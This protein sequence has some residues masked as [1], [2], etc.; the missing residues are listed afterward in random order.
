MRQRRKPDNP[1][2]NDDILNVVRAAICEDRYQFGDHALDRMHE[3]KIT[4]LD[5]R[6][7]LMKGRRETAKDEYKEQY[8]R[9]RYAFRGRD[10][11]A[12][13]LRVIVSEETP[14]VIIITAIDLEKES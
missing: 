4:A 12:R 3:R 9:W 1:P 2:K 13:E 8:K 6:D 11:M 7:V 14:G 5:I 10:E